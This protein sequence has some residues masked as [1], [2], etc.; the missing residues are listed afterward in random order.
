[1]ED[2]KNG[3][4]ENFFGSFENEWMVILKVSEWRNQAYYGK[5]PASVRAFLI[6]IEYRDEVSYEVKTLRRMLDDL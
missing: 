6:G 5:A 4:F 2:P 3:P 1:M